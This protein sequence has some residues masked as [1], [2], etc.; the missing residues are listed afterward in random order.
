[1][2]GT[3]GGAGG[4]I[5]TSVAIAD[6]PSVLARARCQRVQECCMAMTFDQESCQNDVLG[7]FSVLMM[8]YQPFLDSGKVMYRADR[9]AACVNDLLAASCTV[10]KAGSPTV[11]TITLCDEAFQPT[12]SPGGA[13]TDDLECIAGWCNVTSMK[14]V[15]KVADGAACDDDVDCLSDNCNPTTLKCD[16]RMVDGLCPPKP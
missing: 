15:A 8:N 10:I 11:N 9:A 16:P 7:Q 6:L 5:G 14:C 1:M 4:S 12:V 2:G 3:G 13:C